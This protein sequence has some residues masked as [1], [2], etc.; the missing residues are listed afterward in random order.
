MAFTPALVEQQIRVGDQLNITVSSLNAE[1]DGVFNAASVKPLEVQADGTISYHRLGGVK[2]LGMTRRQLASTLQKQLTPFLRDP[3]VQVR[4]ANHRATVVFN[5]TP[6]VI[7]LPEEH[8]PLIEALA[9]IRNSTSTEKAI[10]LSQVTR[11]RESPGKG[12][13]V[14]VLDLTNS[15]KI[16]TPDNYFVRPNDLFI[17]RED[18]SIAIREEKRKR[19]PAVYGLI[20]TSVNILVLIGSNV[21]RR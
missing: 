17:L 3:L 19:F 6:V 12:Q 16:Y 2:V 14:T 13:E 4:F 9:G 10:L 21:F 5:N 20:L 15:K 1:E 7:S 11:V 18:E 8:I